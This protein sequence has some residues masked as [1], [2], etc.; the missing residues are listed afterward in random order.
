V[1]CFLNSLV[2]LY[3]SVLVTRAMYFVFDS[4]DKRN[5]D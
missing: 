4:H 3:V 1:E 5:I 2:T